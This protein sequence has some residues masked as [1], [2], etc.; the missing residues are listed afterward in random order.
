MAEPCPAAAAAPEPAPVP[1]PEQ[2][3]EPVPE[4]APEGERPPENP[5]A[6]NSLGPDDFFSSQENMVREEVPDSRSLLFIAWVFCCVGSIIIVVPLAFILMPL[7][8]GGLARV[9]ASVVS[10]NLPPK[11]D[12]GGISTRIHVERPWIHEKGPRI[13]IPTET[14]PPRT[15][16]AV[17]AG[18]R[19]T[20]PSFYVDVNDIT[21]DSFNVSTL[22]AINPS[23][24]VYCIFNISRLRLSPGI[25]FLL[26][27]FPWPIC[28]KVIYWS[29]TANL[30][31]GSLMS[32]APEL[33]AYNGFYNITSFARKYSN[34]T[35]VL[36]TLGGY[37][38]DSGLFSLLGN[39]TLAETNLAQMVIVMLYHVRFH[40]LNIHLTEDRAC[41][42]YFKG[43]FGGLQ[44]FIT[45]VRELVS[46]NAP[47]EDFKIT[48]M[49]GTNKR[50]AKDALNLLGDLIDLVFFDTYE[51]FSAN[52]YATFNGD[53]FST[54]Y[55]DFLT[56]FKREMGAPS[57]MC[58]SI[59]SLTR[60]WRG[61]APVHPLPVT[62]RAG[63][64]SF[65]DFCDPRYRVLIQ[66]S[67]GNRQAV[68]VD[69]RSGQ[70]MTAYFLND[71]TFSVLASDCLLVES[72][73][74][75]VPPQQCS[76]VTAC[77]QPAGIT[78]PGHLSPADWR[79]VRS[80]ALIELT[81]LFDRLGIT[82]ARR[83]NTR[84][85]TKETGPLYG[86][87]LTTLLEQ[88]NVR[89]A[90][91]QHKVPV[92]IR[93]I[94]DHLR[95]HALQEEGILRVSGSALKIDALRSELES[96]YNGSRNPEQLGAVL[97][98]FGVHEVAGMLK[99][100]LRNLPEPLL[101]N[102]YAEA[103]LQVEGIPTLLE[104]IK[105]L[106]LLVLLLPEA[107]RSTLLALMNFLADVTERDGRNRMSVQNV[108]MIIAP[109]L[110]APKRR[111]AT[112]ENLRVARAATNVTRMLIWYQQLLWIVPSQFM[113]Q[114]RLEYRIHYE[115]KH[116]K[117]NKVPFRVRVDHEGQTGTT[118]QV[119]LNDATT[120]GSVVGE[121]FLAMHFEARKRD[122]ATGKGSPHGSVVNVV[123]IK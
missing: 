123:V 3:P 98:R 74:Y 5:A 48:L 103:F 17:P 18:C 34:D 57:K 82:Y 67:P 28:P 119:A 64:G 22:R 116:A 94:L 62:Q 55:V 76:L 111:K 38:E 56:N 63:F 112:E 36:F 16:A 25:D 66:P 90:P 24:P 101:T 106:N 104:Q 30:S 11:L 117:E 6:A 1:A 113:G 70:N 44:S 47:I 69:Q 114:I 21:H 77:E 23:E 14:V 54:G 65:Q 78:V 45:V 13:P 58:Y 50:L 88:D 15:T 8:S 42:Q 99:Q 80:L 89:H 73:E 68:Y 86:V 35:R 109:N 52:S 85:K 92:I 61:R 71:R 105:A 32:R 46:V 40:G 31:D 49:V 12:H 10:S 59:S 26:H 7:F 84:R 102:K 93:E 95:R 72:V 39:V 27:Q 120:A 107:N 81:A 91:V 37:L 121:V 53:S 20:S 108:A 122:I 60:I 75:G 100:L 115:K 79:K 83:K 118:H 4:P 87:P 51:L 110:F 41:E 9:K 33:D 43:R 29:L 97:S 96:C 19:K 2:A